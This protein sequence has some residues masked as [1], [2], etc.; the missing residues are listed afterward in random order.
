MATYH[1]EDLFGYVERLREALRDPA[2]AEFDTTPG[3]AAK[4]A[5]ARVAVLLGYCRVFGLDVGEDDGVLP[6]PEA[7]G[8]IEALQKKVEEL[9]EAVRTLPERW[10]EAID[11]VEEDCICAGVLERRM[12]LWVATVALAEAALD[13]LEEGH[14]LERVL[15]NRL[16]ELTRAIADVDRQIRRREVFLILSTLAETHLL[17]NWR[18][19]LVEPYKSFPPYWLDGSLEKA[20]EY[21]K[22][23]FEVTARRWSVPALKEPPRA[24]AA[25][26]HVDILAGLRPIAVA[27]EAQ[28]DAPPIL[29]RWRSPDGTY[30]A[31]LLLP[32]QP[33]FGQVVKLQV[34]RVA[35][36]Q[37]ANELAGKAVD[38]AGIQGVLSEQAQIDVPI[39]ELLRVAKDEPERY[40]LSIEGALWQ[41]VACS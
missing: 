34:L 1:R 26:R 33:Y 40:C 32:A 38:L 21:S 41:E 39:E 28:A 2:L 20:I 18:A 37:P 10:D 31:E 23:F 17:D 25:R 6:V 27:A 14:P 11:P 29:L 36:D 22:K 13:A 7:L 8:A 12:D 24:A 16:K 15:G 5:A 9:V 3:P 19:M 4:E 35:D 30:L